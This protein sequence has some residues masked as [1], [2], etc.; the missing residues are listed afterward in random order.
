[1]IQD[2]GFTKNTHLEAANSEAIGHQVQVPRR[3]KPTEG[4]YQS[5]LISHWLL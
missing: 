2:R 1:M 3:D 4:L 5:S